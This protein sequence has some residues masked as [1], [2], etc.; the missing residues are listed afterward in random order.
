MITSTFLTLLVIPV[1]Y[2]VFA[3]FS[4]W[5]HRKFAHKEQ[6]LAASPEEERE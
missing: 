2:T 6:A 1:I 3:D 4:K 5:I